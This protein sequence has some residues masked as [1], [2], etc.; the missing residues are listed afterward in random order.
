MTKLNELSDNYGARKGRMRVIPQGIS[1]TPYGQQDTAIMTG[2]GCTWK[3]P[4]RYG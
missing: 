2:D 3:K 1:S 4:V